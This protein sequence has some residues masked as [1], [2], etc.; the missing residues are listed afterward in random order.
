MD[1]ARFRPNRAPNFTADRYAEKAARW[2][3]MWPELTAMPAWAASRS[4]KNEMTRFA[5]SFVG[6][7]SRSMRSTVSTLCGFGAGESGL[8]T[9]SSGSIPSNGYRRA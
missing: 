2:K 9:S 1:G 6:S 4:R 7:P 8:A 3:T 5:A